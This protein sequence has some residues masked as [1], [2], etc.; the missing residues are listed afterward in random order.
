LDKIFSSLLF[1]GQLKHIKTW[2]FET[3]FYVSLTPFPC[4]LLF[5]PSFFDVKTEAGTKF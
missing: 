4:P 3:V 2:I 5:C 1:T